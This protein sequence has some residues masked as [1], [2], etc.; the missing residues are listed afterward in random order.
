MKITLNF[1]DEQTAQLETIQKH[2]K[3]NDKRQ[4]SFQVII[5]GLILELFEKIKPKPGVQS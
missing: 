5:L 1:T 3:I 4:L 2:I